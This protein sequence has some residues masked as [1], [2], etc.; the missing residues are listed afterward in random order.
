VRERWRPGTVLAWHEPYASP[1][2]EGRDGPGQDGQAFV[3]RDYACRA[4]VSEP[5][6]LRAVLDA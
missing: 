2:W 4:P 1:L 6:A 5:D 3:C